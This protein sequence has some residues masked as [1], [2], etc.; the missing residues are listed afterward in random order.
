MVK[1]TMC[2]RRLPTLTPAEFHEYWYEKHAKLALKNAKV[3]RIKRYVQTHALDEPDLQKALAGPRGAEPPYDGI[4]E[5]WLESLEDLAAVGA[6]PEGRAAA[7]EM[8]E[9]ERNFI[10]HAH[11]P[12]WVSEEREIIAG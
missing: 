11:S 6:T 5:L 10:D 9:D 8:L 4:A 2:L 12:I 1:V 3:L 7:R